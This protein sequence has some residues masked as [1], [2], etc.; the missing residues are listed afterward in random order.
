MVPLATKAKFSSRL[1]EARSA[2]W[3]CHRRD[4]K[5]IPGCRG[6]GLTKQGSKGLLW[7]SCELHCGVQ[8][9]LYVP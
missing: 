9:G 5:A 3:R 2:C 8:V 7:G 1:D 6:R 4:V